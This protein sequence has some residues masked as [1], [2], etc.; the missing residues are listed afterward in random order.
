MNKFLLTA[1][2]FVTL[3]SCNTGSAQREHG[4]YDII[5]VTNKQ[6]EEVDCD[7]EGIAKPSQKEYELNPRKNRYDIPQDADFDKQIT[8]QEL[9]SPT[10]TAGKFQEGK[11]VEIEGY[12]HSVK[13]GGVESC[14]CKTADV[15][16]RDTHIELI[17]DPSQSSSHS[18]LIVE[19]TPRMRLVKG[20]TEWS[21][22]SLKQ[23]LEGKKV[24]VQGWLLYDEDH[25]LE[26][27]ADDPVDTRGR[28]NWRASCWE[29]HPITSITILD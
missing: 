18:I 7:L 4:K 3:Y 11:A 24:R 20:G 23:T 5:H 1:L 15:N 16:N 9:I 10:A 29:V 8:L 25:E 13:M 19:V 6:G 17:P 22:H 26:N 21:T 28:E 2:F 12:V 27:W 14:N